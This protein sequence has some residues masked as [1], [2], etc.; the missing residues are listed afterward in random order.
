MIEHIVSFKLNNKKDF[1]TVGDKFAELAKGVDVIVEYD[2]QAN[3]YLKRE[4]NYD[5]IL[6][7]YFNNEADLETYL[8]DENHMQFATDMK[9]NYW[10]E[11]IT[12]DI[13]K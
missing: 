6:K 4:S 1:Q 10:K 11:V 2:Y 5:A 8:F 12:I 7:V 13:K 3:V 9:A